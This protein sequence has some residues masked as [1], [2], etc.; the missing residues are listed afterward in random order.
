MNYQPPFSLEGLGEGR[1]GGRG[2]G[3]RE[4]EEGEG[5]GGGKGGGGGR[6]RGGG[7]EER[8]GRR[9]GNIGA[10]KLRRVSVRLTFLREGEEGG[11]KE[12]EF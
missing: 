5:R 11:D 12:G 9:E 1:G 2:G 10:D 8:E 4:G 7:E 3:G 6:G